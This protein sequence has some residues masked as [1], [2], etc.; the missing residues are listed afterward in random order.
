MTDTMTAARTDAQTDGAAVLAGLIA[1]WSQGPLFHVPGE[2]ALELLDALAGRMGGRMVSCRH[3]AGAVFAA[4]A[5]GHATGQPGIAVVGRAP[6]ALN[7]MLALHTAWTDAAPMILIVGQATGRQSGREAYLGPDFG[8]TFA[9]AAKWV[10]ECTDAAR[11][12]EMMLRAWSVAL[13]GQRGPVVLVVDEDVWHQP[14][15]QPAPLAAP[16]PPQPG[17][18]PDDAARIAEMLAEAQRPLLIVGGTGWDADD[19]AALVAYAES[20]AL[21]VLTSYRR[22]DL[23][24]ASS[25]SMAG[26]LGIGADPAAL[27]AV[28]EA[29]LVIVAGMRLGEINTFGANVF[30]GYQLM[31]LP[32]PGRALVHI[33]PDMSELNRVWRADPAICATPGSLFPLLDAAAPVPDARREWRDRLR[34]SRLAFTEGKPG[35]GPLDLREVCRIL[36]ANLPPDAMLTVGAGAYAHWPQRYVPHEEYGTQLG[37]KSGAMGYGLPA[38]I[39]VQAACPGRRVV[40]MAGDGCFLMTGEELAT[41]VLHRLPVTVIV[42][43]NSRYG[44]IAASQQRQFGRTVGTDLS[45]VNFADYARSMGVEGIRVTTTAE[46]APALARAGASDGPVLI[47]LVTGPEA[48]KP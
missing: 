8:A 30:A 34:A 45:P 6:G 38:A 5:A 2:G 28:G 21:P 26:E 36:R 22:R 33:H 23:M 18:S 43:N 39:G 1:D 31:P 27:A 40:A 7:A 47:E 9:G 44:A 12:P 29:D 15:T 35:Q 10:G 41:A 46:F 3:E 42:V 13:S 14:V 4:Q 32:G 20:Q 19:R 25:P 48:L 24:P 11:L 37:P 16:V 17:V